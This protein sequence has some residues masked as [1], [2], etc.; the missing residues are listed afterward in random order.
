MT[1]Y[2]HFSV[3]TK[4][5]FKDWIMKSLGWPLVKVEIT[6][7]QLGIAID[8]AMIEFTEYVQY[9][10]DYLE[11]DLATYDA[12]SGF[13]LPDNVVSIFQLHESSSA[14][15]MGSVYTMF[16][17][18]SFMYTGG[19]WPSFSGGGGGNWV[20]YDVAMQYLK[21]AKMMCG[22]GFQAIYNERTKSL[23]LVPSPLEAKITGFICVGCQT[24]RPDEQVYGESWVRRMGLAKAKQI[25]GTIRDKYEGVNLLGGG[26]ISSKIRDEGL[27]E[28]DKLREELKAKYQLSSFMVG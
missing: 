22:G 10:R 4:E 1:N 14:S 3:E 28:A 5:Q 24:I 20:T 8:D 15:A 17:P 23:K 13:T 9:E 2:L 25:I 11:L 26:R 6:D 18:A 27:Q 21:L 12:T 16:S 7:D 19:M